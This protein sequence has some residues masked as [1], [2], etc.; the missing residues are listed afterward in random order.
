LGKGWIYHEVTEFTEALQF[1]LE[2]WC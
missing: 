2:F 1:G